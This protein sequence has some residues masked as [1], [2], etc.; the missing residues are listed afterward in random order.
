MERVRESRP[1]PPAPL[2]RGSSAVE[3]SAVNRSVLGSN[4]SPGASYIRGLG[5]FLAQAPDAFETGA[6]LRATTLKFP[7]DLS[8]LPSA[9]PQNETA[10]RRIAGR[11]LIDKEIRE[12]SRGY[13]P[14]VPYLDQPQPSS[15]MAGLSTATL[16]TCDGGRRTKGNHGNLCSCLFKGFA[17][18]ALV[19][20]KCQDAGC[21]PHPQWEVVR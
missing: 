20:Q 4:P 17:D 19:A 9:A 5:V 8:L 15:L 18:G 21:P 11:H 10:H 14:T 12:I 6:T 3:Q 7:I 2:F 13:R 1:S 16:W